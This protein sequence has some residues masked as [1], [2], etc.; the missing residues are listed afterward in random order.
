MSA[1]SPRGRR[2]TGP[3]RRSW[4]GSPVLKTRPSLRSGHVSCL[5][6]ER[7]QGGFYV[8]A[9]PPGLS[10]AQV[11]GHGRAG[12]RGLGQV[13]GPADR[14]AQVPGAVRSQHAS[15]PAAH[16]HDVRRRRRDHRWSRGR[17]RP[18]LRR[19]P[20]RGLARWNHPEPGRR[21]RVPGRRTARPGAAAR[22]AL[23]LAAR[24]GGGSGRSSGATH[25]VKRGVFLLA[26]LIAAVLTAA[27]NI[28]V[29]IREWDVPT[30]GSRPHDPEAA[31]D[32]ALW[33]T[34]QLA[35]K[36]GRL[37]PKSGAIREFPVRTP[38]SGPHGLAADNAGNIWFTANSKGYIGK[39]DPKTGEVTEFP[40]PDKR[41]SDPHSLA[42][43]REG[44]IFFTA[45]QANFVGRLDP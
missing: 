7:R 32:G 30:P 8:Q 3:K 23:A 36:L 17:V 4:T 6:G 11:R 38:D 15:H 20:R 24:R 18:A 5:L 41:V 40:M 45:Q 2:G 43:D 37:D 31:P 19:I 25:S 28:Q 44:M 34:G 35:N 1:S 39:L 33:Y 14:M 13:P 21:R 9:S 12:P 42:F 16:L 10:N 27:S 29:V 26:F 22:R